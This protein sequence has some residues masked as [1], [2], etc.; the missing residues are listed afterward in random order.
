MT[1]NFGFMAKAN[2]KI[3]ARKAEAAKV[4]EAAKC[5][6]SIRKDLGIKKSDYLDFVDRPMTDEQFRNIAERQ[7]SD[8]Q[9]TCSHSQFLQEL[10]DRKSVV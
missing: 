2:A 1:Q 9:D 4:A 10:G 6:Q 8:L 5:L 3:E 7:I